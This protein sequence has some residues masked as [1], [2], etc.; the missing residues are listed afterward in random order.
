MAVSWV[1]LWNWGPIYNDGPVRKD[2]WRVPFDRPRHIV[3]SAYVNVVSLGFDGEDA[4]VAAAT[5]KRFE[6]RDDRGAVREVAV[7]E[8]T[9]FIE[10]RGCVSITLARVTRRAWA[11][12]GWSIYFLD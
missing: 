1:Q 7:D 10:V 11:D 2:Y 12:C 6:M 8:F 3:A 5:F 9:A 4:G